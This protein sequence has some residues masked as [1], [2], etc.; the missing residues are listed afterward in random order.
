MTAHWGVSKHDQGISVA[1]VLT[2]LSFTG[3]IMS[4]DLEMTISGSLAGGL[5]CALYKAE[6]EGPFED[7]C[8]QQGRPSC[9]WA[10]VIW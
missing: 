5:Q 1:L 10:L 9:T 8:L 6:L 3:V 4:Y 2:M 7:S